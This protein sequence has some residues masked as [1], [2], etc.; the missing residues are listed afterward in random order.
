MST[1]PFC[2]PLRRERGGLCLWSR[3]LGRRPFN[4]P[5]SSA[6]PWWRGGC[7]KTLRRR[8]VLLG[9]AWTA[10][11]RGC[12]SGLRGCEQRRERAKR[13]ERASSDANE[14]NSMLL[15]ELPQRCEPKAGNFFGRWKGH[16]EGIWFVFIVCHDGPPCRERK[17]AY[18]HPA[19]AR[20]RATP[21]EDERNL[22]RESRSE[23]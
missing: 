2:E 4:F 21:P 6:A 13:Y 3:G 5:R 16:G 17:F 18:A 9:L 19:C 20:L 23:L 1:D 7:G 8:R 11:R 15:P 22:V 12:S 14:F 10:R